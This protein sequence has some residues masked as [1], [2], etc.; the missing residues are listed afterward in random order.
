MDNEI[1]EHKKSK[2]LRE[3]LPWSYPVVG[4]AA[5]SILLVAYL[6]Q[7]AQI[8]SI[9]YTLLELRGERRVLE[10]EQNE[11]ELA[12]QELTSLERVE[13]VAVKQLGMVPPSNR[14]VLQVLPTAA[15]EVR[16]LAATNPNEG[17]Q[18]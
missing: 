16:Q 4:F 18:P 13:T 11:L 10:R 2:R 1:S 7:F 8:V 15:A 5:V 9:Q 14:E 6:C 3:G 17:A 12:I